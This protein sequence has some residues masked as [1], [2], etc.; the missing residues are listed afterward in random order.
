MEYAYGENKTSV[1]KGAWRFKRNSRNIMMCYDQRHCEPDLERYPDASN[2]SANYL[3]R[4]GHIGP[5]C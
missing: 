1:K 3:C 5:L 2:S 4:P